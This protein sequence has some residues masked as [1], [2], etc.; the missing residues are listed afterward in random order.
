MHFIATLLALLIPIAPVSADDG[1]HQHDELTD[2]QLGTVHFPIS[3]DARVQ[4]QFERGVA[5]LHSFAFETAEAAFRQVAQNDPHCAMAHWGIASTFSRWG[6]PDADQLKH[7]WEEIKIAKSLHARTARERT[8]IAAL[9]TLYAH[10]AKKDD[11][12][13]ARH[14]KVMERL[15]HRYPADHEAAA[16]YA[17]DL[18]DSDRDDDPTHAARKQA[19]AILEKLF[20]LEPD[21]PGVAHYLI[22]TY[23]YPGMAELGIPA[24]RR[25]AQIAPAAPHALHMPSHI[26][27]R[28]GM[29]DEDIDSNLASIAA[30][31][32]AAATHMGDLGHQYHAMEF[33]IYA[34]LQSGREQKA[35]QLIEE[36]RSLPKMKDMYGAG[37]DPQISALTQFSAGYVMEMHRWKEAEALPLISPTDDADA[38]LT[39][40]ARA[41]GA[42]R[43]GDLAAARASL[44]A[45]QDLHATLVKEKKSPVSIGAVEDDQR[46]V[47]AWIDHAE[48]RNEDAIRTLR[49]MAGTEQGIFAPDGGIPAH[50]MLGDILTDMGQ[51]EQALAEYDAELRLSPNRFNS[52]Y[53]AGRAA[54]AARQS[55]KAAGYYRQLVKVCT[56]NS[57]RTEL[58]HAREFLSA[59]ASSRTKFYISRRPSIAFSIVI[60][61]V[62]SISLPT[63]MPMAMRVTLT[64]PRR[65]CCER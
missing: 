44:Q 12:R 43:M 47:S 15:Y 54:E 46:V 24:A 28:L 45:M 49:K 36:V 6:D 62:Y 37:F 64:P 14:L 59:V 21:H 8:Y 51:P 10:P 42:C 40:K 13:G 48:G 35:Q 34:Y 17:F 29:W 4:G 55:D 19:A 3:C 7:G 61:S 22:H 23:D 41:I 39:Y 20:V 2:Q 1:Q 52:L 18:K 58:A 30:S 5:L 16:F 57:T 26:F 63:G 56:G 25:Y 32:N 31:R 33:L 50:E 53:G 38:S 11:R 9:A 27:A 65:S 60:S